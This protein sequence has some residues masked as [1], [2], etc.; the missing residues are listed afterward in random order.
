[1]SYKLCEKISSL[2]PYE[3]VS[4]DYKHKL[5]A[6][7]SFIPIDDKILNQIKDKLDELD[8]NRYPDPYCENLCECF[9]KF[10]GVDKS[11]IT[12]GNGSDE[13]ISIITSSFLMSKDTVLT[14]TPDFSMYKFYAHISEC[15]L[16]EVDKDTALKINIDTVIKTAKASNAKMI[17]FSNPCNPTSLG[18][19]RKEIIHLL[20][21]VESLVVLDEAYM[22]FWNESLIN[23]VDAFDN[24]IILK[25]ASKAWGMASV[26]LGFAIANLKLTNAIKAVKSP[27]NVNTITQKI[28]EV[29]YSNKDI[30]LN[31][32]DKILLQRDYLYS[33]LI[34]LTNSYND[35]RVYPSCTNFVLIEFNSE[36][37]SGRIYNYLKENS[38]LVRSIG[39]Y[40]RVTASSDTDMNAFL[41]LFQKAINMGGNRF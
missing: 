36:R 15:N 28:G 12:V 7:E 34:L 17:I 26:R 13:L 39:K 19:S 24:L 4:K 3:T 8:F 40:L 22:D 29:I 2:T 11:Y 5:D 16:V 33:K 32:K 37:E 20:N 23:N 9:A 38:V 25:T 6:N 31:M 21:S 30:L 1:M 14:I 10:Y 27:Y 35:I 41:D 18:I